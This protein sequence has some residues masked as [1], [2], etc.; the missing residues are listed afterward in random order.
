MLFFYTDATLGDFLIEAAYN[1]HVQWHF[2]VVGSFDE[3]VGS[4]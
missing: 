4:F 2:V 3:S 1:V